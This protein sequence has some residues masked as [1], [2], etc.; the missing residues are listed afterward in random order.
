MCRKSAG[1]CTSRWEAAANILLQIRR[2]VALFE[3][4]TRIYS[5]M[6]ISVCV[7]VLA[8]AVGLQKKEE[9]WWDHIRSAAERLRKKCPACYKWQFVELRE[10]DWV[11]VLIH[12]QKAQD[13]WVQI[14]SLQEECKHILSSWRQSMTVSLHYTSKVV[15]RS[16]KK[17]TADHFW[18]LLQCKGWSRC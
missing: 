12:L 5:V 18:C 2:N 14:T 6:L 4:F 3:A 8:D 15:L 1:S 10:E 13:H 7:S 16:L 9:S 11:F 17:E